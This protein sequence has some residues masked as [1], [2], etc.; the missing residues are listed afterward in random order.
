L[1]RKRKKKAN[2]LEAKVDGILSILQSVNEAPKEGDANTFAFRTL[3]NVT[4]VGHPFLATQGIVENQT[5]GH[6]RHDIVAPTSIGST[7]ALAVNNSSD[8]V[9]PALLDFSFDAA[10]LL[11]S[12][13][14]SAFG[15]SVEES[16]A[17]LSDFRTQKLM[18]FPFIHLPASTT[19]EQLQQERPFLFLTIMAVSSKSGSQRQ[20]LG[21]EVKQILAREFIINNEGSLD[22]LIGL[23]VFLAWLV[24]LHP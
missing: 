17:Y 24:A 7:P 19:I 13:S 12:A 23:L 3:E 18:C 1:A 6:S 22:V 8:F 5:T 21:R 20:G 2:T 10:D 4:L 15:P 9:T 14:Y 16:K 11:T